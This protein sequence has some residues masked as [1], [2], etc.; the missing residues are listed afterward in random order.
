M[1]RYI[2]LLKGPLASR[3]GLD[4]ENTILSLSLAVETY[5]IFQ[6]KYIVNNIVSNLKEVGVLES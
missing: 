1:Y 4:L 3:I 2:A 5:F 6:Y